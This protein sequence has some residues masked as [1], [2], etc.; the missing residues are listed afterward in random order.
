MGLN[1]VFS[2]I[3]VGLGNLTQC[4]GV[5]DQV[6]NSRCANCSSVWKYPVTRVSF[7]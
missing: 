3:S 2:P 6:L 5:I 7:V 1:L 4:N